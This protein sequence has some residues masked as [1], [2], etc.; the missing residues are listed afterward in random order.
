MIGI[1]KNS[2]SADG[3]PSNNK[4]KPTNQISTHTALEIPAY[5]SAATQRLEIASQNFQ[6]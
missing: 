6:C 4:E 2:L 5:F 3:E 1:K